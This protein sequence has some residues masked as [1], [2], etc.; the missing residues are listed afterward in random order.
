METKVCAKCHRE[1]PLSEFHKYKRSPDGHQFY[2]KQCRVMK[3][4][5]LSNVPTALLIQ[6][7][8]RREINK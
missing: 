4:N 2:C 8:Y 3:G 6:E 1:L 5:L 7:L